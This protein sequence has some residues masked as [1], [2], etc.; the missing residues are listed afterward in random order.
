M[1]CSICG[2]GGSEN[3]SGGLFKTEKEI[4]ITTD[5]WQEYFEEKDMI[6]T[7]K[8]YNS[9]DELVESY[10]LHHCIVL[11]DGYEI[12][13]EKSKIAIEYQPYSELW[14]VDVDTDTL[15]ISFNEKI[16]DEARYTQEDD[17]FES[18]KANEIT[19]Y[20]LK[21]HLG[22]ASDDNEITLSDNHVR[23]VFFEIKRVQGTIYVKEK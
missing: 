23:R 7:H 10:S 21:E 14:S 9:F 16:E 22:R 2:C 11:K 8:E 4:E 17:L 5:N 15:N 3:T 19:Y 13:V 20:G 18:F 1:A 6:L 12:D